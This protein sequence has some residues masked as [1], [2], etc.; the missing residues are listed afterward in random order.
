MTADGL[1]II[2]SPVGPLGLGADR[3]ALTRLVLRA[4]PR[5]ARVAP[6]GVIAE[7][8]R[9]LAAYFAGRLRQFDVPLAFSGTPFQC[10]VWRALREIPYGETWS[11]AELARQVGRPAAMR[12]VG[13]ANAQ[14]PI[15]IIVPCHRVIGSTG[16]LVGFGGG[17]E[18]KRTLLALEQPGLF[19]D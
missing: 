5:P 8:A 9:Q 7:A 10:E 19:R 11:Y 3:D 18:M 12:A 17:L 2:D 1:V 4:P 14:N 6:T 16:K 15:P 13:A